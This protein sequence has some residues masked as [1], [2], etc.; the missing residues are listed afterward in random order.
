MEILI[1]HG[2]VLEE[3]KHFATDTEL[4]NFD[5]FLNSDDKWFKATFSLENFSSPLFYWVECDE[6]KYINKD[7]KLH[8]KLESPQY[9]D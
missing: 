6:P 9:F 8:S 5:Y 1:N 2:M 7:Y 3:V 4:F